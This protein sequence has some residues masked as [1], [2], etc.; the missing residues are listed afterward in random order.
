M[1]KT[2]DKLL[3]S[4]LTSFSMAFLFT[5]IE[6]YFYGFLPSNLLLLLELIIL[7]IPCFFFFLEIQDSLFALLI[8][9][10]FSLTKN[11]LIDLIL[12]K[13]F[14]IIEPLI[15][16]FSF[17]FIGLAISFNGELGLTEAKMGMLSTLALFFAFTFSYL[18]LLV[19][20]NQISNIQ[21]YKISIYQFKN[22]LH[23]ISF[24]E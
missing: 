18:I 11:I 21:T 19:Y 1:L 6:V 9:F 23:N 14:P 3:F 24:R 12:I 22:F 17:F 13:P 5:I 4:F 16:G 15:F 10:L 8:G 2:S 7:S 20:F